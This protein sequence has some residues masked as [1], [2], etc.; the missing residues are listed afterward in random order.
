MISREAARRAWLAG[1]RNPHEEK[2]WAQL[3]S[4]SKREF[5][6]WV[7]DSYDS[8]HSELFENRKLKPQYLFTND[9]YAYLIIKDWKS[10]I[11]FGEGKDE[12]LREVLD[13][14]TYYYVWIVAK[15]RDEERYNDWIT[16]SLEHTLIRLN[17]GELSNRLLE[18]ANETWSKA[19]ESYAEKVDDDE[20]RDWFLAFNKTRTGE[21]DVFTKFWWVRQ[22]ARRDEGFRGWFV[23]SGLGREAYRLLEYEDTP[24]NL[25]I[26]Q[27][28]KEE[29]DEEED[30]TD[31]LPYYD[32]KGV[33]R[34]PKGSFKHVGKRDSNF[35]Y[36]PPTIR[37]GKSY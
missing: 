18:I 30:W 7:V 33:L 25:S 12:D 1:L 16:S 27:E 17:D 23:E 10:R 9:M 11:G 6:S 5:E 4:P 20:F 28:S 14:E 13:Y 15:Y 2:P 34:D 24:G 8:L 26:G 35:N 31:N 22:M 36:I 3:P 19:L 32:G 37:G 21:K 29:E